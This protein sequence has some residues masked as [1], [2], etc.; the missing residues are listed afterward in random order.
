[1]G[2]QLAVLVAIAALVVATAMLGIP[3]GAYLYVT[4][5]VVVVLV[6]MGALIA[7]HG[8]AGVGTLYRAF[9]RSL[10][11]SE[12]GRAHRIAKDTGRFAVAA[13]WTL[14]CIGFIAGLR[15]LDDLDAAMASA[16]AAMLAPLYG[17]A[18]WGLLTGISS[19]YHKS[20]EVAVAGV[21]KRQAI[22]RLAGF[23]LMFGLIASSVL[24]SMPLA[25][26]L[27]DAAI[28]G[29]IGVGLAAGIA[30]VGIPRTRD[31][32][33][34]LLLATRRG[35]RWA[36]LLCLCLGAIAA[37]HFLR[38]DITQSGPA[39]A[40]GLLG[41]VYGFFLGDLVCLPL[42]RWLQAV[43]SAPEP[44]KTRLL[45]EYPW[46]TVLE[47]LD[48]EKVVVTPSDDSSAVAA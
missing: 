29:V 37:L 2:R 31:R 14:A 9:E 27:H 38:V 23:M 6:A 11:P 34:N 8:F 21:S 5:A 1:M 46:P 43:A 25:A 24:T 35:L 17:Y 10:D 28:L 12:E 22:R 36:A 18:I 15:V 39:M 3:L 13:G 7:A 33:A 26:M 41:L 40:F 45:P 20:E 44:Q 47:G 30:S 4:S 48:S 42:A 19:R 16:Q 32:L